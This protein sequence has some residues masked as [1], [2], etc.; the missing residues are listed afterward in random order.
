LSVGRKSFEGAVLNISQSGLAVEAPLGAAAEGDSLS[1][2]LKPHGRPPIELTAI[3]WNTRVVRR[4]HLPGP[5]CRLG[6]VLSE[7]DEDYFG[8]VDSAARAVPSGRSRT[9]QQ[10]RSP[11]PGLRFWVQVA[12]AGGSRSR[13]I[14]VVAPDP[15]AARAAALEEAGAGWAVVDVQRARK[16]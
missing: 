5:T 12:Q 4:A 1:L 6:L 14:L 9:A 8:L 15:E 13:T 3:V 11:E 2:A 10:A 16:A 7:A